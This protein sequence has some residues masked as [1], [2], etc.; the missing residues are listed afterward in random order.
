MSLLEKLSICLVS[1]W[2]GKPTVIAFRSEIVMPARGRWILHP[3]LAMTLKRVTCVICQSEEAK[4]ALCNLFPS[5][6]K[7][8][9]VIK[10]WTV[11]DHAT[12][13]PNTP[14]S[15]SP[16]ERCR[17]SFIGWLEPVKDVPTILRAL[18]LVNRSNRK[19]E[20]S[21]CGSGSQRRML[22][23]MVTELG[24]ADQ[25]CFRGWIGDSEK[26]EL[27]RNTDLFVMASISEGMPNSLV[28]AM[29]CGIPIVS[30]D[31]GGI[32][33]LVAEN[34]N[35][36]L[37]PPGDGEAAADC[38][39]KL[40][41]DPARRQRFGRCSRNLILEHHDVEAAAETIIGILTENPNRFTCEIP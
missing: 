16:D 14:G 35:G 10:N 6:D 20:L 2:L 34:E 37:F 8:I 29:S 1:C 19:W 17:I 26:R 13:A 3:L 32:P 15:H 9:C 25:V 27:L 30:S 11:V 18:E 5:V 31:A 7:K 4:V 41:D 23:Q 40:I 39:L 22:E 36:L 33:S 24:L 28:E 38:L 12:S 21:I